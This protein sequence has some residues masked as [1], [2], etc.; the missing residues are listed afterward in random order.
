MKKRIMAISIFIICIIT[1]SML[2]FYNGNERKLNKANK[3]L[4]NEQTSEAVVIFKKLINNDKLGAEAKYGLAKAYIKMN[5]YKEAEKEL[6]SLL[7]NKP[8]YYEGNFELY[9][10]YKKQNRIEDAYKVI[11]KYYDL[12]KD[13][14]VEIL[15]DEVEKQIKNT[16]VPDVKPNGGEVN[17]DNYITINVPKNCSIYYTLD[18]TKP[19]KNS[20]EYN[21][22]IKLIKEGNLTFKI[23]IIN[24]SNDINN[25]I[26]YKYNIKSNIKSSMK[27][28]EI[29]INQELQKK[30]NI[31]MSNFAEV[32][33]NMLFEEGKISD[34]HLILFGFWHNRRN[35]GM[36][37]PYFQYEESYCKINK[38]YIEQTVKKYY[39]INK[40]NHKTIQIDENYSYEYKNG[41]YY[42]MPAAGDNPIDYSVVYKVE[43]IGN[44]QYYVYAK[45]YHT[46]EYADIVIYK[47]DE[48]YSLNFTKSE[49]IYKDYLMDYQAEMVRAKVQKITENGIER[50]ILLEYKLSD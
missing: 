18:G 17:L 28:K 42:F 20:K 21:G 38:K 7:N 39:N 9:N 5:S 23:I 35:H 22:K 13:K 48:Y 44:N 33:F 6:I 32:P 50:Y 12:N 36:N 46:S 26:T 8:D 2:F 10:L 3:F 29:I 45:N 27:Y 11:K 40:I 34:R 49:R 19:S 30:L 4:N 15:I 25:E 1:I 47:Y 43:D 24:N 14:N 31:F 37:E 16:L 41:Y